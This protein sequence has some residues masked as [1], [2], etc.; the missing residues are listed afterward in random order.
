MLLFLH[1]FV[2]LKSARAVSNILSV[3][4]LCLFGVSNQTKGDVSTAE[5]RGVCTEEGKEERATQ[6]VL[7]ERTK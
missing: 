5:C 7:R 3:S 6:T 4:D 1:Y 2:V